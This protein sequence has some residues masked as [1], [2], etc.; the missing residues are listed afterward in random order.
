MVEL[1]WWLIAAAV[2]AEYFALVQSFGGLGWLFGDDRR[3]VR[4]VLSPQQ[5]HPPFEQDLGYGW[6]SLR[7]SV[8]AIWCWCRRWC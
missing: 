1:S 6:R 3:V 5:R 8:A 4:A 2:D 7:W